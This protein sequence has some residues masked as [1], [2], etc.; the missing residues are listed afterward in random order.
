MA[1]LPLVLATDDFVAPLWVSSTFEAAVGGHGLG[2]RLLKR[3]SLWSRD[4]LPQSSLA[5]QLVS[6]YN[7]CWLFAAITG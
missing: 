6:L 1:K 7:P 2:L 3:F 5:L 4:L